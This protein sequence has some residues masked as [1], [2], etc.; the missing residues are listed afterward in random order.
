M[1][2]TNNQIPLEV[3]NKYRLVLLGTDS[4]AEVKRI[5]STSSAKKKCDTHHGVVV[6]AT[7][8][9]GCIK[10]NE[11]IVMSSC[12]DFLL[13]DNIV[14][15]EINNNEAAGAAE[16]QNIGVCFER[17]KLDDLKKILRVN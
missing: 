9:K 7:I 5:F 8:T 10:T 16:G 17:T 2:Q 13:D 4:I 14:R 12:G 1:S 11:R 15:I 6:L 3:I